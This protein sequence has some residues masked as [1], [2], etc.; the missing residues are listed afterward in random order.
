LVVTA[1]CGFAATCTSY[2]LFNQL[3]DYLLAC[4]VAAAALLDYHLQ[5][6]AA[7]NFKEVWQHYIFKQP[8]WLV[9]FLF[10]TIAFIYKLNMSQLLFLAHLG[11]LALLYGYGFKLGSIRLPALRNINYIKIFLI[12]YVWVALTV[13]LPFITADIPTKIIWVETFQRALFYLAL[14]LPFDIRDETTDTQQQ[15]KTLANKLGMVKTK[16][17]AATCLLLS[18]SIA[19]LHYQLTIFFAIACA[20][21]LCFI[22]VLLAN[23]VRPMLYFTGLMD[24]TIIIQYLLLLVL[25]NH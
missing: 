20:N 7:K 9:V 8:L 10:V 16:W 12:V 6:L 24:G 3:P 5:W 14:T 4:L 11:I 21:L 2:L 23:K 18:T 17:L 13:W 19:F 22:L 25:A 1:G 15:L